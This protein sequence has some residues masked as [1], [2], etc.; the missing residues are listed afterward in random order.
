MVGKQVHN[1]HNITTSKL[2]SYLL[3]YFKDA[4]GVLQ[5][6]IQDQK[7]SFIEISVFNLEYADILTACEHRAHMMPTD[8]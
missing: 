2:T 8:E 3:K 1:F 4:A 7:G 5:M 6:T